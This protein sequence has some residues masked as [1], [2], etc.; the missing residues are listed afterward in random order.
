METIAYL[1]NWE[2]T[3]ILGKFWILLDTKDYS[4]TSEKLRLLCISA[5]I[6]NFSRNLKCCLS[7]QVFCA[8][9]LIKHFVSMCLTEPHVFCLSVTNFIAVIDQGHNFEGFGRYF[10][11]R[12]LLTTGQMTTF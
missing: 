11:L 1:E 5:A 7:C 8:F 9:K 4:R 3:A 12:V 10:W 2:E 6:L